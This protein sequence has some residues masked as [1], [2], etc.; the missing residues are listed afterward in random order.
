LIT[1]RGT[2]TLQDEA[3]LDLEI[4]IPAGGVGSFS[5]QVQLLP[6]QNAWDW[7]WVVI[8]ARAKTR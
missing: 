6:P 8:E 1:A 7:D 4:D 3:N 5:R 2:G